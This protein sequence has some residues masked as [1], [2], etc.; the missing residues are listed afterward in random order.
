VNKG[1]WNRWN[2]WGEQERGDRKASPHP[3]QKIVVAVQPLNA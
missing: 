2:R 1:R 3:Q